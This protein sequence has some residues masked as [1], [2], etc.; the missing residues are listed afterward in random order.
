MTSSDCP[1]F[2]PLQIINGM[3]RS[4]IY[5]V[6]LIDLSRCFDVIGHKVLLNKL[7]LLQMS[8]GWTSKVIHQSIF[9]MFAWDNFFSFRPITIG[10]FQGTCPDHSYVTLQPMTSIVSYQQKWTDSVSPLCVRYADDSQIAITSPRNI[11]YEIQS[12]L[13]KVLNITNVWF[14]HRGVAKRGA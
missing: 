12:A 1:F 4:E 10:S 7:K 13:E 3:D 9:R 8:T 5:L 14:L 11:L 6:T 2:P